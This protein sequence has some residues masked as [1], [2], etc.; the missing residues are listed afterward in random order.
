MEAWRELW[1]KSEPRHPLWRHQLDTAA[2]S[3]ELRNPLL[4]EGW[5]AEQLAL[6]VALHDIGKA[7]ASFQ[8]QTGGSLSEDLQRAGFGLTS[9][10]KCRHERLSARFLRGAFKSADQEQDADT[11]ARCVLAHHGYWCEGARGVGNAYEKAQQ[12][13]CSMLQD[14]LGVRFDTVPAVKDHSSFGMRLCGHIVLCDWIASNEAFFTDGRLKGIECPRDYLSAARTVARDW[15]DRLGLRRPDQTPPRPRDVVGK[16]RPLQQTLLEETIPPGLVI[17]EAPMGEGKTEAAWILAEKWTEWGFHGMYMALP[18][19]ATSDALHGRYRQDYLEKLG[20]GNQAKLVHGMAWLRDDTEPENPPVAGETGEDRASAAAWFRPT[21][22]AMLA[23]HG[24]GT[25]DQA[26]LAGMNVKFGFLRLFGLDRRVVVI[27]EV[28]AYD[29]YMSAI[30]CRLLQWCA[31]LEIPVILLSATLSSRQR[32]MMVEA[33]AGSESA[34]EAQPDGSS[35]PYPLITAVPANGASPRSIPADA[36]SSRTLQFQ[37]H[38]GTFG[39]AATTAKLALDLVDGGG[40]CCVILNT[41]KQAQAVYGELANL[42][43]DQKLLFHARFTAA[44]RL[45]ITQR[46]LD[47]FGKE[48][49]SRPEKF[50]L[51]ATQVVEQSLDVDFDHMISEIAPMDLLLQRSGRIKRHARTKDG[52]LK[53]DGADERGEPTLHVLVPKEESGKLPKLASSEIIYQSYPLLTTLAQ[54]KPSGGNNTVAVSLPADFRKLIEATYADS[55]GSDAAQYLKDAKAKWDDLQEDLAAQAGEFLLCEPMED[56]FDPVGHDEVGDESDD[57]NGWR[58][59]TRIGLEDVLVIPLKP[60]QLAKYKGGDLHPRLV[61][62]LYKR[63]IKI[64]PYYWPPRAASGHGQPLLGKDKLK[65]VWLLP[66][67]PTNGGWEWQGL[68]EGGKPYTIR[69]DS[70]IGLTH[71]AD[72]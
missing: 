66:A 59:R 51:V 1:A 65:G 5:S 45:K 29:A 68:K 23:A 63:S 33:Y 70:T 50:V 56:E 39:D 49:A 28:H 44:D 61:K 3:L 30:L 10:S 47:L 64:P 60:E 53:A 11:I 9:D 18:T 14:V 25:V 26:M 52:K 67:K 41:V 2:V 15:V 21:R 40:C 55:V 35:A 37:T 16:P 4:H 36:S 22:R 72:K 19:M 42:P 31:C 6:V 71:E 48:I 20:R 27:D 43:K 17:I 34:G 57:G 13:L 12:D 24:V 32:Q 46:V 54:L 8:H 58:A 62:R 69:Y 7:D 38:P